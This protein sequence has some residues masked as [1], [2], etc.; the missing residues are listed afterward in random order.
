METDTWK[1][2]KN[3]TAAFAWQVEFHVT[4]KLFFQNVLTYVLGKGGGKVMDTNL[5]CLLL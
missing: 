1:Q 2:E 3:V 5:I 4:P